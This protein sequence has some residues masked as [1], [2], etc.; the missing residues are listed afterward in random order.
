MRERVRALVGDDTVL[1]LPS[2]ATVAPL[3]DA[4]G[5]EIDATRMRTLRICCIAGLAGLPQVSLPL[6]TAEGL[7]AGVSLI[8]PAG[9]DRALV[10]LAVQVWGR[11]QAVP[12]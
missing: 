4:S 10:Q 2:A 9:S 1:L 7:P 8:G 5:P 11:L 6:R 3:R 12:A